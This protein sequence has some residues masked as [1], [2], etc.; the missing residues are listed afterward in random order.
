MARKPPGQLGFNFEDEPEKPPVTLS[1]H[2]EAFPAEPPAP[3]ARDFPPWHP[4]YVQWFN[5][6][7]LYGRTM[8][9]IR[10]DKVTLR[11]E[12]AAYMKEFLEQRI[13]TNQAWINS[14]DSVPF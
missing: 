14:E 3:A 13:K 5:G 1:Y 8:E 10:L 7:S 12:D 6:L 2:A 11:S 9:Q 4:V